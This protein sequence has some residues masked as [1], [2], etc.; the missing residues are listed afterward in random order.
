MKIKFMSDQAIIKVSQLLRT[1]VESLAEIFSKMENLT[2]KK[3]VVNKIFEENRQIIKQKMDI[4]G[5]SLEKGDSQFIQFELIK[6]AREADASFAKFLGYPDFSRQEGC[7]NLID[8]VI[9]AANIDDGYFL[10]EEKMR[11]FLVLNPPKNIISALGYKSAHEMLEKEDIYEVFAALRFVENER[12]LNEI[13]FRPFN[14]LTADSFES[15]PVKVKVLSEKWAAIG[16][17][18]VGKKL[19]NI[20]HL[21]E[22]GLIFIIPMKKETF[23][24]Q[25]LETFSLLLH[26]MHEIDFY[27][28]LFRKYSSVSDFGTNIVKLL[29]GTV[30]TSVMPKNKMVWRIIQRYLAKNDPQDPRL[31]EAHVNPETVH[32]FK[33]ESE[34]DNLAAANP[35]IKLDFW[36]GN[37]DFA[38]EIFPAG[39]K[40]EEIVSFDLL[41]NIISLTHG[42]LSKYL[43]H[44]QAALWNKIFVEFMGEQK[45]EDLIVENIEKGFIEL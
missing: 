5:V 26:Y 11:G 16:E 4:L 35:Q 7:Q 18:F 1:P 36:R 8:K 37:D 6:K 39:R 41:D 10:K 40:G 43:Y 25:N 44:Q 14:D 32:W 19:H 24:G 21:K 23:E 27:C 38:G 9:Q 29:S 2:G 30:S 45:L 17:K 28:R 31:F 3:D 15:R 20:S 34:I 33:A 12:W 42:G 22:M 13:F